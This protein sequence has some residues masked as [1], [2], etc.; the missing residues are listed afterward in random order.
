MDDDSI[1]DLQSRIAHQENTIA[2]L[3][4]ALSAQQA[5]MGRLEA[6]VQVLADRVRAL[7]DNMPASGADDEKPPHY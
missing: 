7:S 5:Q 4:E 3:N 2:E 1:I 6:L